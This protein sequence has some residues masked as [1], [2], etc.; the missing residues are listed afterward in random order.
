MSD[1]RISSPSTATNGPVRPNIFLGVTSTL[2]IDKPTLE[3]LRAT[4]NMITAMQPHK[5]FDTPEGC[6]QRRKVLLELEKMAKEWIKEMTLL[7][8]RSEEYAKEVGGKIFTFG[9]YR[10]GVHTQGAD[11]DALLVAPRHISRDEVFTKFSDRLRSHDQ[12]KHVKVIEDAYVPVIKMV[13]SGIEMDLTYAR[14]ALKAIPNTLDLQDTELLR[15]LDPRCIRSLNGCRVTDAI[16]TLV[17]DVNH[18]E[19]F[20]CALRMIKLWAK[21]R[22]IYSN[23]MGYLGGVSWAILVARTCQ[24]YPNAS[25]STIVHKFFRVFTQW[26]WPQP[27]MLRGFE[28]NVLNMQVWDARLNEQ[29]AMHKMPIITPAYPEQN[30]TFNVRKSTLSVMQEEFDRASKICMLISLNRTNWE[31]LF[32]PVNFFSKYKHY[33]IVQLETDTEQDHLEWQGLLESMIRFLIENLETIRKYID[34]ACVYPSPIR[35]DPLPST[36]PD[37]VKPVFKSSYF[38]GLQFL[39][40]GIDLHLAEPLKQFTDR[41]YEKARKN[42]FSPT[43]KI[44]LVYYKRSN[45]KEQFPNIDIKRKDTFSRLMKQYSNLFTT[46]N[47]RK[48]PSPPRNSL[49]V[50]S[51]PGSP[52]VHHESPQGTTGAMTMSPKPNGA[53]SSPQDV[54]M[55]N[56]SQASESNSQ[57]DT[58]GDVTKR[59]TKRKHELLP[60]SQPKR[61]RS[62]S[63]PLQEHILTPE[64]ATPYELERFIPPFPLGKDTRKD[65][66]IKLISKATT[67]TTS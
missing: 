10:L 30:T 36:G 4:E 11:I 25:A 9:S 12:I 65:I 40:A 16:L 38:V 18:K 46:L 27:I 44:A 63:P 49:A 58:N 57:M 66:E 35:Q 2:N 20:K 7:Q 28:E 50:S 64:L 32:E 55:R 6:S 62:Q 31:V 47:P 8:G 33:I 39:V 56:A 24:L 54:S 37:A 3:D 42:K 22:G 34:V 45:L 59:E 14:L 52:R 23:A 53:P 21:N 5:V 61:V 48:S 43:G 67:T 60:S 17:P 19:A 26:K 29:D 51:N 15:N 1:M 41:V 13:F